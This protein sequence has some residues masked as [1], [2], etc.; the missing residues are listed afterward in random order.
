MTTLELKLTLPDEIAQRAKNAGLLT[1]EAIG[2]L[3]EEA[4]R[5]DA[6]RRLLQ[7]MQELHASNIEPMT[8]NEVQAVVDEVRADRR[9]RAEGH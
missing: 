1:G 8:E 9:R 4:L 2:L 6:G 5:R 7:V 3:L